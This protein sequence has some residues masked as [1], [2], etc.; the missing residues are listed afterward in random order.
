MEFYSKSQLIKYPACFQILKFYVWWSVVAVYVDPSYFSIHYTIMFLG[1]FAFIGLRSTGPYGKSRGFI[2]NPLRVKC[3]DA[4][5][6]IKKDDICV[7]FN[8][9]LF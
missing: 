7:P 5:L 9:R 4:I 1:L 2:F 8:N 3:W 6:F